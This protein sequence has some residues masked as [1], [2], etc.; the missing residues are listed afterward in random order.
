[1]AN[2]EL[3]D[4]KNDHLD[5]VLDPA[6]IISPLDNPFS[7]FRFEH[8]ALPELD[9]DAIDLSQ[10]FLGRTLRA[11]V[12]ISSMTGGAKRAQGINL[13]LAEAAEQLGIALAIGSQ[14]VAVQTGADHGLV[15]YGLIRRG[16]V[17]QFAQTIIDRFKVRAHGPQAAA[18]SLSGGN[19]QKFIVGR[20]ALRAPRVLLVAQP[21]WGVDVGAAGLIRQALIEL[22]DAGVALLVISEELDELFEISDR[23]AV[24]AGGRLS[25]ALAVADTSVEQIGLWMSGDFS[26]SAAPPP[27]STP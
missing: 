11:P 20:E 9:F 6:R 17:R 27:S 15:Q 23:I 16:A 14:R 3:V 25:R 12:L 2:G 19:L 8:C 22:R 13:H 26:H 21:T 7:A 10:P 5:I 24:L 4:R 1:M 18:S